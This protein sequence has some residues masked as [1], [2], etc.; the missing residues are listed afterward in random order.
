MNSFPMLCQ[1]IYCDKC[2]KKETGGRLHEKNIQLGAENRRPSEVNGVAVFALL[3][4]LIGALA[5]I[6]SPILFFA[7]DYFAKVLD[8]ALLAH[9]LSKGFWKFF[10]RSMLISSALVIA[11]FFKFY[12]I[13]WSGELRLQKIRWARFAITFA[14]GFA[15][16][17]AVYL[18]LILVN[19][20]SFSAITLR[21][22]LTGGAKAIA[23][24]FIIGAVE[25]VLFRG[26][27]LHLL[28][29]N[30]KT[31]LAATLV[32][33]L[34]AALHASSGS[35]AEIEPQN[36][37][38]FSGFHCAISHIYAIF[39][40]INWPIF[41]NLAL[42][43]MVLAALVIEFG[44]LLYPIAF[45]FGMV[46][47]MMLVRNFV[48][49]VAISGIQRSNFSPLEAWQTALILLLLIILTVKIGNNF[50]RN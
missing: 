39:S 5:A 17:G 19:G 40:S 12:K 9:F 27:V 36:V 35:F 50:R 15:S 2:K 23:A 24:A 3:Y 14:T 28:Q 49:I 26:I 47:A 30:L 22:I 48:K 21:L 42:L 46:F 8:S 18:W 32:S 7:A 20:H 37:T 25:E 10:Q 16:T 4:A 41:I 6:L 43:G 45:H 38:I 1:F 29:K 34:F 13:S 31:W 33:L 44:S 11:I